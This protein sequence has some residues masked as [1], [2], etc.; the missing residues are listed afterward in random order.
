MQVK[1]DED[2]AK[3]LMRVSRELVRCTPG[4]FTEVHCDIRVS[5]AGAGRRVSY[6]ITCPQ[7]PEAGSR[8]PSEPLRQAVLALLDGLERAGRRLTGVRVVSIVSADNKVATSIVPLESPPEP[9]D[10]E[11][12]AAA[13]GGGT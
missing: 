2:G 13:D 9:P 6:R 8:Q 10:A 4:N 5:L 1:L 7:F 11:P 3:A 12:G